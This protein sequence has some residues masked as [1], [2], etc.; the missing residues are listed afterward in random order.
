MLGAYAATIVLLPRADIPIGDDWV[1]ARSVRI[2]L[3]EGRVQ[4]LDASVVSLVFQLLWGALFS[5]VLGLSFVVL[6]LSTVV[7]AA[8]GAIGVFGLCRALG[9]SRGW[10]A[11]GA[12][13]WL[14]NPL[15]YVL[16]NSFMTDASFAALLTMAAFLYV[17]GLDAGRESPA[18]VVCG[19]VV[20]ALAFLTRQQGLLIPVAVVA[21]LLWSRRVTA[22]RRGAALVARVAA[23]PLATAA[24][25]WLWITLGH[26]LPE[27]Q[28]MFTE[29]LGLLWRRETPRFLA[30]LL[31]VHVMYAGLFVLP[32]AVAAAAVAVRVIRRFPPGGWLLLAPTSVVVVV[33]VGALAVQ[34]RLMPYVPQYLATWGLGPADIQG[35]RPDLVSSRS[36]LVAFTLVAAAS[37]IVGAALIG[38]KAAGS[39][40]PGRAGAGLLATILAAQVAGAVP[41]SLHFQNPVPAGILTTTLDRYLLPMLPLVLCLAVWAVAGMRVPSWPAWVATAVFAVVAVGGTRDFLVFQRA[42]WEVA[43]AAN[44]AGIGNHRLEAGAQWGGEHLYQ[45]WVDRPPSR[46]DRPWWVNLFAW[47]TD[48][49]FVVATH[50]LPGHV[51]VERTTYDMWLG[52]AEN[53]LYLLRREDVPAVTAE[54][55][56]GEQ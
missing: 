49:S 40:A 38:R 14:F 16:A 18:L 12:A 51:E 23:A 5:S 30:E 48:S 27:G 50:P 36:V 29:E 28:R 37:A 3:E 26:G 45:G 25:Y 43:T 32:V 10:S 20:A 42:T 31:T 56:A 41:P 19:S 52:P 8:G 53:P 9:A 4:I 17:R 33:G 13:A 46:P 35:G 54:L 24:V 39:S 44:A 34:E 11:V 15:A 21:F 55:L 2:L 22:D 6:R 47:T 1:Y 7:L